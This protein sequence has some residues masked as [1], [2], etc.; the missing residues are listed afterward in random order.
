VPPKLSTRWT[1]IRL[2]SEIGIDR[3]FRHDLIDGELFAAP[4][5]NYLHQLV[6]QRLLLTL[7]S[8]APP[9]LQVVGLPLNLYID[10]HT[11]LQPDLTVVRSD[12]DYGLIIHPSDVLLVVEVLSPTTR[13]IDLERKR[14]VYEAARIPSYWIIDP[15]E[16]SI[17][18]LERD[19]SGSYAEIASAL[20][21]EVLSAVE[22]FAVSVTPSQLLN[23]P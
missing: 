11:V 21:D 8:A 5:P 14:A 17:V 19:Q 23:G 22:P 1:W 2:V 9:T 4:S 18:V 13:R 3:G 15:L 12:R 20:G 6:A 7:L 10:E 16:A